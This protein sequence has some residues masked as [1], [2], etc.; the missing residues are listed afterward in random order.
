MAYKYN[1]TIMNGAEKLI[2]GI[3]NI[4]M[5]LDDNDEW[6]FH[7]SEIRSFYWDRAKK[8]FSVTRRSNSSSGRSR[9]FVGGQRRKPE[10]KTGN[11]K[12]GPRGAVLD[13]C[14]ARTAAE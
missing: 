9:P 10:R 4:E 7:D 6:N 3:E 8:T 1:K 5:F 13:L 11:G 14:E 12:G 2:D